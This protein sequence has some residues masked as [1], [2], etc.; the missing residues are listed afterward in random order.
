M[1]TIVLGGLLVVAIVGPACA[2]SAG[3]D[4]EVRVGA[5]DDA[6]LAKS[7]LQIMGAKIDGEPSQGLCQGCHDV[8]NRTT[9]TKWAARWKETMAVL[10]DETKSKDERIHWM[11]RDPADARSGFYPGKV[12]ILTAGAHLGITTYVRPDKHPLTYAQNKKLAEL[13]EGQDELWNQFKSDT[14][15]P[16][17]PRFDRLSPT[18]YET[19]VTWMQKGMPHLADY[20]AD[21]GRPTSCTDDFAKLGDH[22]RAMKATS[23]A[24]ANR[25]AKLPMF[26]C[27]ANAAPLD[28]FAQKGGSGDVFPLSDTVAYAKTW[29]AAH[30]D[31]FR[32][33]RTLDYGTFY[34]SRTSPD[35]RFFAAGGGPREDNTRA[36]VADLAAAL[37]GKTRD[38]LVA[39][40]YDPDFYPSNNG[41]M[42]QGTNKG[43]AFCSMSLLTNPATKKVTFDEPQ[44]TKLDAIGLYQ[45][46]GQALGDNSISDIFVVN[47]T[48]ASDNPSLT[49][50]A[51]DLQLTAGPEAKVTVHVGLA[52]GN[53]ADSGYQIRQHVEL[54]T[55][56][57]GDTM[58]SRSG[59]ILG[60]RIAGETRALG[61]A[62][63][64]LSATKTDAGYKFALAPLGRVCMPGNKANISFDERFLV[65]HHYAAREDFASDEA[66]A[67]YAEKG[68]ADLWLADFVTGQKVKITQMAPGQFALFPHFRSDGWIMFEVR[69]A[70]TKKVY[71]VASDAALRMAAKVPTP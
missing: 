29:S 51:H 64:K 13:F 69:D 62:I 30:G 45:T 68:A 5:L 60:S 23:W 55:P 20:V 10:E 8:D 43:G 61:Y 42:F 66:F 14:L 33:L 58:M 31:R 16:V 3:D 63:D 59:S 28:C 67:G 7:A 21:A 50:A 22:A 17:E 57:K 53:D 52:L 15:M 40:S 26:A 19:I 4:D 38:I 41:F 35:G 36:V 25:D 56:F 48:F 49:N 1:R 65:S 24:A 34:W 12:G 9:F 39:A 47:S 2:T 11:L 71:V 70:N 37:D 32:I 18:Q 6:T 46:V 54:A 27:A 44:C